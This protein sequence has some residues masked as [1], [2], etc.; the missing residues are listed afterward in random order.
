MEPQNQV[1]V[2]NFFPLFRFQ[3]LWRFNFVDGIG[4]QLTYPQAWIY[5]N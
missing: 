3:G 4:G 2:E 5:C 1:R